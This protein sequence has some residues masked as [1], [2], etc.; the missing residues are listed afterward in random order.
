[1]FFQPMQVTTVL[2]NKQWMLRSEEDGRLGLAMPAEWKA[3]FA[4]IGRLA[5]IEVNVLDVFR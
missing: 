5:S 1:M 3:V 2:A 4:I